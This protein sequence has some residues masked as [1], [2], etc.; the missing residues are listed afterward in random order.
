MGMENAGKA[1]PVAVAQ[2]LEKGT[3]D[4]VSGSV[5]YDA[6]HNPVKAAVVLQVKD[7]AVNYVDTVAP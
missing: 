5:S 4:V 6:Q 3:F 7:G 2:A 1:D